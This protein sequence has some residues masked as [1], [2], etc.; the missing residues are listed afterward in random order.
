[1]DRKG[2]GKMKFVEAVNLIEKKYGAQAFDHL[3]DYAEDE[4]AQMILRERKK[5]HTKQK[6]KYARGKDPGLKVFRKMVEDG[7]SYAEIM[8]VT[9]LS[10]NAVSIKCKQYGLAELY[11]KLHPETL[12]RGIAVACVNL[13]T[14]E[15]KTYDT[16]LAASCAFGVD[17]SFLSRKIRDGKI[18]FRDGWKIKK[19][20]R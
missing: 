16:I 17:N 7:Y 6:K 20:F 9:S 4:A 1:M 5:G 12:C 11:H 3:E 8:E 2:G 15:Q 14:G 19:K 10:R 18:Y 13:T